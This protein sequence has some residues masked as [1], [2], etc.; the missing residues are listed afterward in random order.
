MANKLEKICGSCACCS[1]ITLIIFLCFSFRSVEINE[2]GLKY[3]SVTKT[4][5]KKYYTPGIYFTGLF[6]NFI[7]FPRQVI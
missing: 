7:T 6:H 4:I 3:S 2:Y 1:V 5:E